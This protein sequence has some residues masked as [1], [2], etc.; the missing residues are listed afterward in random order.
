MI[1]LSIYII[2]LAKFASGAF[3]EDPFMSLYSD[4]SYVTELNSTTFDNFTYCN[5]RAN[6]PAVLVVVRWA[7]SHSKLTNFQFYNA[8][9]ESVFPYAPLV[10]ELSEAIN[11]WGIL[12]VGAVNCALEVNTKLCHQQE[13][14]TKTIGPIWQ[15]VRIT[16]FKVSWLRFFQ[17]NSLFLVLFRQISHRRFGKCNS[18]ILYYRLLNKKRSKA[19]DYRRR[20]TSHPELAKYYSA[21]NVNYLN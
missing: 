8:V 18:P 19:D 14:F 17:F 11:W 10:K 15:F 12:K 21:S 9:S 20:R 6:C 3:K 13:F 7:F 2:L 16:L 1:R 4:S 5:N